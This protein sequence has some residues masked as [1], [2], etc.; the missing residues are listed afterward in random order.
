MKIVSIVGTRP[1]F[2]KLA[3]LCYKIKETNIE[4]IIIHSGQHYDTEM[5]KNYLKY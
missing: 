4:H 3:P 5:S 1:Q 2:L